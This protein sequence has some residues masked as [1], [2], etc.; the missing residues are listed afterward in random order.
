[1]FIEAHSFS[2]YFQYN[3]MVIKLYDRVLFNKLRTVPILYRSKRT[4][5]FYLFIHELLHSIQLPSMV[6]MWLWLVIW[7][8]EEIEE[9]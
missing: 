3:W 2:M 4:L 9:D 1:M 6:T 5:W 7:Y 8:S